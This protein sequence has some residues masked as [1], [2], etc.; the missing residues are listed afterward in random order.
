LQ[1]TIVLYLVAKNIIFTGIRLLIHI[2]R[3]CFPINRGSL[4]LMDNS[5]S[6]YC[7][8]PTIQTSYKQ[9]NNIQLQFKLEI[10]LLVLVQE[11]E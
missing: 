5:A 4:V 1:F 10:E 11:N 8:D 6:S 7:D 9:Y 3:L 2:L